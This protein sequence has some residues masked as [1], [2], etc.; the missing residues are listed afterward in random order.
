MEQEP[1]TEAIRAG[2]VVAIR[3]DLRLRKGGSCQYTPDQLVNGKY[4]KHTGHGG[5]WT[6]IVQAVNGDMAFVGGGWRGVEILEANVCVM[7]AAASA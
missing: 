4:L 2:D 5:I 7:E 1:I 6:G 3:G